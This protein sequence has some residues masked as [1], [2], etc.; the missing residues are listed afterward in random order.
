MPSTL[1][2]AAADTHP[3]KPP[4]DA[5]RLEL[6]QVEGRGVFRPVCKG[7]EA[8]AIRVLSGD[9]G[10]DMEA[11]EHAPSIRPRRPAVESMSLRRLRA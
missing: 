6:R 8:R 3:V 4:A 10:L 11:D 1:A 5:A 2:S 9:Q 7:V